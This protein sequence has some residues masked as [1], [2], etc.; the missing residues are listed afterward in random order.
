MGKEWGEVGKNQYFCYKCKQPI[1]NYRE[2]VR[3]IVEVFSGAK[4]NQS[5]VCSLK[6]FHLGCT[7]IDRFNYGQVG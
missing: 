7:Y 5:S 3:L 6:D 4:K 2:R 1:L